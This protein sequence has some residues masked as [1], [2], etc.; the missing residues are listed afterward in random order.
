M[1][2]YQ[3][4]QVIRTKLKESGIKDSYAT[5]RKTLQ[6]QRR[7]TTNMRRSDGRTVHVRKTSKAESALKRIYQALGINAAPGRVKKLVV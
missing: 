4:V 3:C 5:S 1:L 7:T 2:P 6:V